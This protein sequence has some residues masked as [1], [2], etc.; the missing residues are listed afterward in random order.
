M[1]HHPAPA[2]FNCKQHHR[3]EC[4]EYPFGSSVLKSKLDE[5]MSTLNSVHPRDV[6]EY[7]IFGDQITL[8]QRDGGEIILGGYVTSS[9]NRKLIAEVT[10]GIGQGE[11]ITLSF[12]A[13]TIASGGTAEGTGA[14]ATNAVLNVEGDDIYSM[15]LSDR[16]DVYSFE[17]T[18]VDISNTKSVDS[19]LQKLEE[20]LFG[21]EISAS[22]DLDGN[23]FFKEKMEAL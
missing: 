10:P 16:T 4:R 12:N 19:F 14:L 2:H 18:I 5:L 9:N 13:H 20:S 22:M 17:N 23:I 7:S 3:L 11:K 6:F 15:K 1:D 8:Y 21:S